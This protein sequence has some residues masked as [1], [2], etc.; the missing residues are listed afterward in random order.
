MLMIWGRFAVDIGAQNLWSKRD[1]CALYSIWGDIEP[2]VRGGGQEFGLRSGTENLPGIA[3][4]GAAADLTLRRLS[5]IDYLENLRVYLE[6]QL[7]Q[8]PGIQFYGDPNRRV[9]HILCFGIEGLSGPDLVLNLSV[10]ASAVRVVLRV[11]QHPSHVLAAM[12][13]PLRQGRRCDKS[14]MG[15]YE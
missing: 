12:G 6:D 1:R 9:P 11:S 3:G 13:V 14:R 5:Q 8:I 7:R 15:Q 4:L 2:L 10:R